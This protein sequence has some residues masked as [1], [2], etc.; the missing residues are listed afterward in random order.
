MLLPIVQGVG[1]TTSPGWGR[2]QGRWSAAHRAGMIAIMEHAHT[3]RGWLGRF[4]VRIMQLRNEVP[5]Y[6]AA[7]RAVVVRA[8]ASNLLPER[9][10]ELD[11]TVPSWQA[12]AWRDSE[13]LAMA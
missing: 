4:A 1:L 13:I 3:A 8:Y 5:L 7:N 11:A 10:A 12:P 9:A 6:E 2:P